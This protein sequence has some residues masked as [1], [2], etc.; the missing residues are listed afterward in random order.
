MVHS[1][2][3]HRHEDLR[4]GVGVYREKDMKWEEILTVKNA[5]YRVEAAESDGQLFGCAANPNRLTCHCRRFCHE[6]FCKHVCACNHMSELAKPRGERN[7]LLN[8][9][10]WVVPLDRHKSGEA[11]SPKHKRGGGGGYAMK[12]NC[13]LK[14]GKP[15]LSSR[16]RKASPASGKRSANA[17]RINGKLDGLE[18]VVGHGQRGSEAVHALTASEIEALREA[19]IAQHVAQ[20]EADTAARKKAME[21]ATRK[22]R[23]NERDRKAKAAQERQAAKRAAKADSKARD[24]RVRSRAVERQARNQQEEL[25]RQGD[26]QQDRSNVTRARPPEEDHLG[27]ESSNCSDGDGPCAYSSIRA[28]VEVCCE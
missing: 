19:A 6:N 1:Y 26:L 4:R 14:A 16:K 13:Y 3:S 23:E 12:T 2:G 20:E 10:R 17:R 11:D 5:L 27:K 8:T 7:H 25:L 21:E 22:A 28:D 24:E 9:A 15:K 18:E